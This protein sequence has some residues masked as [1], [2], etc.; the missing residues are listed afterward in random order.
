MQPSGSGARHVRVAQTAPCCT[1][2]APRWRTAEQEC[3]YEVVNGS[4]PN[5]FELL[6]IFSIPAK[7]RIQRNEEKNKRKTCNAPRRSPPSPPDLRRH[8]RGLAKHAAAR[9]PSRPPHVHVHAP[10]LAPICRGDAHP[11]LRL[12]PS[13]VCRPRPLRGG[14]CA[15]P[16]RDSRG[17]GPSGSHSCRRGDGVRAGP[18]CS[19]PINGRGASP[20]SGHRRPRWRPL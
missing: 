17:P 1:G 3:V 19:T 4:S 8:R 7:K 11:P 10:P 16:L 6:T 14:A 9:P 13:P 15:I 2:S 18:Q 5:S 12:C 20:G